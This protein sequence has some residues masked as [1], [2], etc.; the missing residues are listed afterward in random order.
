MSS[1]N[2]PLQPV[3]PGVFAVDTGFQRA[4]FDAAYLLVQD[5]RAAFIDTGTNHSV[6]R[7]LAAL[8]AHGL[9]PDHVDWLIVTHVHLD[10]AGGAGLLLQQLPAAQLVVH[11]RG[12]RHLADPSQ[13]MAGVRAVYGEATVLRDY[14]ELVPVPK[15]RMLIGDAGRVIRLGARDLQ[16]LDLP[17]HARH[18]L[19]IWD[20]ASGCCFVGDT[21]GVCYEELRRDGIHY[22]LPSTTPVQFDP[23]ALPGSIDRILA[24]NPRAACITHYGAIEPVQAQ[25]EMVLRQLDAMVA[26]ARQASGSLRQALGELYFREARA[27]GVLLDRAEFESLIA[28]DI[29]LNAQGLEHWLRTA[30]SH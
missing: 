27:R 29:E 22:A 18:H 14:G 1:F 30:A 17:G 9:R 19:G 7:L 26:L 3:A 28:A 5:G 20:E 8:H 24:L 25:A 6:P 15:E 10:H 13:L 11:P 21:L 23:T 2:A 4:R 12:A 16:L